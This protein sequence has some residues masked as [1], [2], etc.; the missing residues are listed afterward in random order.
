MESKTKVVH[1]VNQFFAGIGGEEKAG[2][3]LQEKEGPVGPGRGLEENSSGSLQVV[4]SIICGDNY[5]QDHS[6]EVLTEVVKI[7][8]ETSPDVFVA[9]PAF[10]AGRYGLACRAVCER[11]R[12]E[13]GIPTVTA[14]YRENPGAGPTPIGTYILLCGEGVREMSTIL[15]A[16]A[17]FSRRLARS[18]RIGP[19]EEEGYLPRGFRRNVFE[20]EIGAVRAVAI[21]KAK[22]RGETFRT[23]I[24][25][26]SFDRVVSPDPISD[27]SKAK[28]VL[29][30]DGGVVPK[31]NPDR[32]ESARATKWFQYSIAGLDGLDAEYYESIHGGFDLTA[33]N[34]DPDRVV[35]VDVMRDLEREGKIGKLYDF[36]YSTTGMTMPVVS[37]IRLG[38]EIASSI[39]ATGTHGVVLTGT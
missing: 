1:F 3:P 35:P 32:L 11:V 25:L 5:F 4:H 39:A 37:S 13:I 19:A 20:K 15:P 27:L 21:L 36:F 9:G 17:S 8:K 26:P 18:E 22:I 16:L 7:V 10:N 28:I 30:T 12:G 31:G 33:V 24:P 23:E 6:E 34:E 29:V 14:M 38:K 2:T